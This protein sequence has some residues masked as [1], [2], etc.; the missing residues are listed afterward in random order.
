[1]VITFT[2]IGCSETKKTDFSK[3]VDP[4]I[5]TDENG[6][7]FPGATVPYGMVQLSPDTRR[8]SNDGDYSASSGYHY[9][10]HKT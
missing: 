4:I 6:H 7:T 10:D 1:M 3:Y 8:N 5:G 2:L 9:S